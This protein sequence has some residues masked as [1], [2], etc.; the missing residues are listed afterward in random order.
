MS[1]NRLNTYRMLSASSARCWATCM[2]LAI[3]G[4]SSKPE[5]VENVP[6][7]PPRPA[8][9]E[10]VRQ[11]R[12]EIFQKRLAVDM[13]YLTEGGIEVVAPG[14]SQGAIVDTATGKL[15][16]AA[17][18]CDNP[19]CPGRKSDNQPLLFPSINPWLYAKEDGTIGLR[20]MK[21]EAEIR[22]TE[23]FGEQKCPVCLKIRNRDSETAQQRQQ[24]QAWCRPH[25]LPQAAQQLKKLEQEYRQ[26]LGHN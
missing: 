12:E 4:C 1:S 20:Q 26:L 18:Q 8:S 21:T 2:L 24:Y 13:L 9:A 16:W 17:W 7:S 22:Q 3:A 15:A 25:V 14:N 5:E 11:T 6:P 10:E 19:Q 23:E